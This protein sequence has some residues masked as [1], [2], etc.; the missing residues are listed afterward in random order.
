MLENYVENNFQLSNI[1]PFDYRE[2]K[3]FFSRSSGTGCAGD[4]A[5]MNDGS[6]S[7]GEN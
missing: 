3:V 7:Q 4:A 1:P 6:R 5:V 2:D